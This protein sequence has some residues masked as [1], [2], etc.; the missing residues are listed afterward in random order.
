MAQAVTAARKPTVSRSVRIDESMWN[1]AKARASR[2]GMNLN[3]VIGDLVEG[4]ARGAIDLTVVKQ[5][6]TPAPKKESSQ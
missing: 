4:Y 5:F 2:A 3:Q 1:S 6:A